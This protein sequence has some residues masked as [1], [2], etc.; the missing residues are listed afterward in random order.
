MDNLR[1]GIWLRGDKQTV[2][3][4]YKKEG[5]G[6]FETLIGLVESTV[7]ARIFRVHLQ[8]QPRVS[9]DLSQAQAK[10]EDIHESLTKEVADATVP[11]AAS[12][13]Q[14][15][16]GNLSDLATALKTAKGGS[17]PTPGSK[18]IKIGRND[19]CPCGSGLKYKKCGL[20]NAP[21]H[22]G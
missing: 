8:Q 17:L 22:R 19:L 15:T 14:S 13:P 10:K 1:D 3:S 21:E 7:A 9:I 11:T 2:L 16:Q 18:Q 6:M 4:E 20:I 5:F 12:A